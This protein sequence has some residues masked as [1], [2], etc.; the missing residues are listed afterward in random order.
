[1]SGF[2]RRDWMRHAGGV[3][4]G[5]LLLAA[6]AGGTLAECT[7]EDGG[8][9]AV[10]EIREGETLILGDGRT[11]RLA[12]LFTPKRERTGQT[13][14]GRYEMEKELA[15]M[16]LNKRVEL[17]LTKTKR[18]RYGRLLAQVM[19]PGDGG[20]SVW[21]QDRL[22]AAGLARVMAAGDDNT[23]LAGLI[24][25][26]NEAREAKRG[27]W[28]SGHF[29]VRAAA[30]EDVLAGLLHS[31]EIVEGRVESVAAIRGRTYV[32]FGAD[33]RRDFTAVIPEKCLQQLTA[34]T[35][36]F[37]AAKLKGQVV[38]VR[39]WIDNFNGPS[40]TVNQPEQI[41]IV[42]STAPTQ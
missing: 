29:A 31:Y 17:K 20:G 2:R 6:F 23:C 4:G 38:R 35:P 16:V 24:A 3:L 25:H 34:R 22:V 10:T 5:A 7:G 8:A 13:S 19:V 32:N 18:D 9:S 26:E 39:G 21:V 28:K 1:M 37:D 30:A 14:E 41:E 11:I 12:N 15:E 36:G 27:L 33:W 40:I 42:A